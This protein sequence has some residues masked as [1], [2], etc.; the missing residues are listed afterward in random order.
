MQQHRG[1]LGVLPVVLIQAKN[2]RLNH[3][4]SKAVR[5]CSK[6][7]GDAGVHS[8]IVARVGRQLPGHEVWTN[9]VEQV[10]SERE[11]LQDPKKGSVR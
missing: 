8:L 9:N 11:N 5:G 3:Q 4:M 1:I 7:V 10:V 6:D 2:G